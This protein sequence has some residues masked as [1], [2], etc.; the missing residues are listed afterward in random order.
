MV[1]NGAIG[2]TGCIGSSDVNGHQIDAKTP[3]GAAQMLGGGAQHDSFM[4]I[5]KSGCT[6]Q[7]S[8]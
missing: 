5:G 4:F 6:E 3:F 1:D 7:G 8:V 2:K